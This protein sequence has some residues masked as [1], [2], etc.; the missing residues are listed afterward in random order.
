VQVAD[1]YIYHFVLLKDTGDGTMLSE[2]AATLE[3]ITGRGEPLMD[4]QLVVDHTQLDAEGFLIAGACN[5]TTAADHIAA[6]IASLELRAASRDIAAVASDDGVEQNMLRLESRELRKQAM[7][8][9]SSRVELSE[10]DA[11]SGASPVSIPIRKSNYPVAGGAS[12]SMPPARGASAR[13]TRLASALNPR[14]YALHL[15]FA[16]SRRRK[17]PAPSC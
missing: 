14:T 9:K 7:L 16:K 5:D 3:A 8:L 6:Q 11:H 17:R 2:R 1:A 10:D 12:L 4:T 13:A 15:G